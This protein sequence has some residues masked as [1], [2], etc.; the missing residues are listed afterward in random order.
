M[1][2]YSVEEELLE[3]QQEEEERA[4]ALEEQNQQDRLVEQDQAEQE[5]P[6]N[7]AQEFAK[8]YAKSAIKNAA[9]EEA[10]AAASAAGSAIVASAPVW[11]PI[12]GILAGILLVIGL[13]IFIIIS[14]A[15]ACNAQGLGGTTARWASWGASFLPG[16]SQDVC[17]QL[18]GGGSGGAGA[19]GGFTVPGDNLSDAA[20]RAQLAAVGITVNKNC[21]DQTRQV[22]SPGQTCLGGTLQSTINEVIDLASKC[23]TSLGGPPPNNRC[24]VL[25]TG[26]SEPGHESGAC[27]HA[28]GYK[29][30]LLPTTALNNYITSPSY[31]ARAGTRSD[32]APLYRRISNNNIYAD[33]RNLPGVSAHWDITADCI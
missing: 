18:S 2:E 8:G 31:F 33:E 16:V 28:N 22:A 24:G 1:A 23:T 14:L 9:K 11:G 3:Q 13:G 19:T 12:V 32:G 17:A 25:V 30:D 4:Q 21:I 26:G 27:S 29:V 10:V 6:V 7:R 20:A 15:S 5:S